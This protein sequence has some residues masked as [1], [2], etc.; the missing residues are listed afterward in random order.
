MPGK[1]QEQHG[2]QCGWS[3]RR[4]RILED[5]G[6]GGK[7]FYLPDI[8]SQLKVLRI[9]ETPSDLPLTKALWLLH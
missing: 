7:G 9:E 5:K 6:Y 3:G 8:K 4:V 1:F 2:D